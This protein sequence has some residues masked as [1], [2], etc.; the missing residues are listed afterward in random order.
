MARSFHVKRP[1]KLYPL[2]TQLDLDKMQSLCHAVD[3]KNDLKLCE[4]IQWVLK[5]RMC[6]SMASNET[7]HEQLFMTGSIWTV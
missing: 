6:K 2:Y 5:S 7:A 4:G 1:I 3:S